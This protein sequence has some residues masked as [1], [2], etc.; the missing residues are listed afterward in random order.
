TVRH[1]LDGFGFL[2]PRR[3]GLRI[4]GVQWVTSVFDDSRAPQGHVPLRALIGGAH[5]PDAVALSDE[6]LV[7][8]ALDGLKATLGLAAPPVFK[9]VIRWAHAIPQ[10]VVGHAA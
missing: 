1:P 10:Y 6:E 5:D 4:L 8:V 9:H 2:V 7:V 3:E